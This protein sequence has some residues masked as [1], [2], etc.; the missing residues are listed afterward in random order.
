MM[1]QKLKKQLAPGI[2]KVLKKYGMKGTIAVS[3]RFSLRVNL[4]GGKIDLIGNHIEA[5][6]NSKQ[7]EHDAVMKENI[8]NT[9]KE[10]GYKQVYEHHA[11]EDNFSG[12]ALEFMTEL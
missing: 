11:L 4:G 5:Y 2:R 8:I 9:I 10:S 3:S 6:R 1:D 12:E 7:D